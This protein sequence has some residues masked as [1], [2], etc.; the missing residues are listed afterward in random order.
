MINSGS[1]FRVDKLRDQDHRENAAYVSDDGKRERKREDHDLFPYFTLRNVYINGGQ[2]NHC[3]ERSNPAASFRNG[4]IKRV[5]RC[6]KGRAER[7]N[8]Q[9]DEIRQESYSARDDELETKRSLF[10]RG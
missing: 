6:S 3:K 5:V 7:L 10:N 8:L 4:E 2:H 1:Q 9:A